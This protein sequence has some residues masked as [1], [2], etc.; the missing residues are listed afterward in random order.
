MDNTP[1]YQY[2]KPTSASL[3]PPKSAKP[4]LTPS[5]EL[6]PCL[7]KM[8]R[9]QSFSGEGYENPYSHLWEFAQTCACLCIAGMCDETLKWKLFLF[10]LMGRAKQWYSQTVGSMQGDWETLYSKFYLRFF[11]ISKV[12]SL[13]KEVLSFR[14]LEEESL[15]T[16]WECVNDLITTSPDLAISD[17]MLLQHFYESYQGFCAI[18]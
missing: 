11:P 18:S 6:R 13:R 15:A 2:A 17:P 8:I 7:I 14:Q 16:S 3:E 5:H 4:I 9:E 10:S 12:V 1:I